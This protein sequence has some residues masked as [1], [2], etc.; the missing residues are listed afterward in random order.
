MLN[1]LSGEGSGIGSMRELPV[2]IAI[3]SL[4][5]PPA[6][7]DQMPP[8]RVPVEEKPNP[9]TIAPELTSTATTRPAWIGSS[10]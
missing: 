10:P 7:E 8:P 5:R 3:T 4:S 6:A 9:L 2:V 1:A